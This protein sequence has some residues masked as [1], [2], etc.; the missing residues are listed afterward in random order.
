[1]SYFE[2]QSEDKKKLPCANLFADEEDIFALEEDTAFSEEKMWEILIIDDEEDVHQL[3]RFVLEDYVYQ[4]KKLKFVSAY[5]AKEAKDLLSQYP[6]IAV[7]LLDVVM[8]TND[9][10]LKLVKYIREI[11][12]NRFT[13]IILR[14][15]QPGYAPEKQVILKYDINDYKNKTEL[16]DQKLFTVMTASLRT[17]SDI[18]TIESYRQ[19]LEDKVAE[20]TYELQEKNK[21]LTQLNLEKNELLGI[22]AHDLKNPLSAIQAL[23][24]L[25]RSA[26][27][28]FSPEKITE[29]AEMIEVSA[30]KMFALIKNLLDV[31]AI[32]SGKMNL[33]FGTYNIL[34]Y[35][36]AVINNYLEPAKAKEIALQLKF[37]EEEHPIKADENAIFQILDNLISNAVKYSPYGKTVFISI[38]KDENTVRC[39]IQDEGPGLDEEELQKLFGKFA[40]LT[41]RPTG[42]EHSTGL[43]LF[44]VKKLVE[45]MNG[46]VWCKSELGKGAT[47]IFEFPSA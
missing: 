1:M 23:A 38:F 45:A 42:D 4:E 5:S 32:E 40:R 28:T 14:T 36:Q 7:V 39:E 20:R 30:Q 43:G 22:A 12:E 3:T 25:I 18:M 24:N 31:N 13:R 41:P 44:I 37:T 11:Q 6:N 46:K 17:Y 27:D 33:S 8:E 2:V 47:F 10:G 19:H 15:G 21:E 9:A 16:T 29:F 26:F 35:L 34:P